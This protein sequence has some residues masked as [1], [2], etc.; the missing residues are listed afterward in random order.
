MIDHRYIRYI[1]IHRQMIDICIYTQ[2][3]DRKIDKHLIGRQKN[4][5]KYIDMIVTY[6][7]SAL[8][9]E[10]SPQHETSHF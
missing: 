6:T 10:L 7:A 8:P 4:I 3:D 5:N 1:Y 9:T 2:V